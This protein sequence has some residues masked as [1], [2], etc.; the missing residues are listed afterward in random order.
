MKLKVFFKEIKIGELWF[1]NGLIC[2][3]TDKNNLKKAYNKKYPLFLYDCESDFCL[4]HLPIGFLKLLPGEGDD[5]IVLMAEINENDSEFERLLK[6]AKLDLA[7][8]DF[9]VKI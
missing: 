7:H 5:D 3:E 8:D 2:Y 4:E 1:N 6:V 9:Y